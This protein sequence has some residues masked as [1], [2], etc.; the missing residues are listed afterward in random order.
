MKKVLDG[1]KKAKQMVEYIDNLL[2]V[3]IGILEK[4]TISTSSFDEEL[5]AKI[6]KL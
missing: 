4:F 6:D 1:V 2:D 5:Q 3:L